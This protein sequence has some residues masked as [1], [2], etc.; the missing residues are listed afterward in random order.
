M[1]EVGPPPSPVEF[2][3]HHHFYKLSCS[4]LLGIAAAPASRRVCLQLTWEVSLP[5]SPVEFSSLCHSHKPSRS[6]L[7]GMCPCS[8]WSLSSPPG[9]FI[10]SSRKDS[11]PPIFSSQCAPPSFLRVFI[12]LIAYY[13]VSLFSLGGGQS[14]QGAMLLWL[15]VVCRSTVVPLSSPCPCLPKPSGCRWLVARGPSWFLHLTWS[16]DAPNSLFK[17]MLKH[18]CRYVP[19][20]SEWTNL[21]I[22]EP[23]WFIRSLS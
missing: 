4:W 12:V 21:D 11:F 5:S 3:S 9:L 20:F 1:W 10:Y 18:V 13:S 7:L 16:G 19:K 23:N 14:V 15:M 22:S 2:S 6:W 8:C 17:G